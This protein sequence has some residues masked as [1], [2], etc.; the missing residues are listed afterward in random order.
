MLLAGGNVVVA[1]GFHDGYFE[2]WKRVAR[3][4][5]DPDARLVLNRS[6]RFSNTR[7][8]LPPPKSLGDFFARSTEEDSSSTSETESDCFIWFTGFLDL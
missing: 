4:F 8:H 1:S 5:G 6:D 2:V 3:Y 7:R